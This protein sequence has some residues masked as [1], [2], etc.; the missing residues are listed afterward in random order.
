V[1]VRFRANSRATIQPRQNYAAG[2]TSG[3]APRTL[4]T[5]ALCQK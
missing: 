2:A 3:L 1:D 4:L 5:T